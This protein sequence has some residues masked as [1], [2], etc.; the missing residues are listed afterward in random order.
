[1]EIES[2][3][4]SMKTRSETTVTLDR[5]MID[6]HESPES[7]SLQGHR[8]PTVT[9]ST[10]PLSSWLSD[11]TSPPASPIME[12]RRGGGVKYLLLLSFLAL[13]CA[14]TPPGR[15][16]SRPAYFRLSMPFTVD[17]RSFLSLDL[18]ADSDG[19]VV[20]GYVEPT[21]TRRQSV[22]VVAA[23]SAGKQ[24]WSRTH[25]V[26]RP[27]G[28]LQAIRT[29]DGGLLVWGI[30]SEHPYLLRIDRN[31]NRL[32]NRTY[33]KRSCPPEAVTQT[34]DGGFILTGTTSD[35]NGRRVYLFKTDAQGDTLWFRSFQV[36]Y[37]PGPH[38]I[39]Q[40]SDGGYILTGAAEG[41]VCIIR[42]DSDGEMLWSRSYGNPGIEFD[43]GWSVQQVRDGGFVVAGRL[44][45]PLAPDDHDMG[46]DY[47][48]YLVRMESNGD[49]LWT[50]AYGGRRYQG[51][52]WVRQTTDGGFIVVGSD[53]QSTSGMTSQ[54]DIRTYVVRTN[55]NGDTLWTRSLGGMRDW[56]RWSAFK[57]TDD[58]MVIAALDPDDPF[59]N[60]LTGPPRRVRPDRVSVRVFSVDPAG[61]VSR[62]E[63]PEEVRDFQEGLA[64][65]KID[66]KWGYVDKAAKFVIAPQ[67]DNA[68]HFSEGLAAV[69][70]GDR[71]GFISRNGAYV[72]PPQFD[73]VDEFTHGLAPVKAGG[74][75]GFVDTTG[76]LVIAPQFNRVSYFFGLGPVEIGDTW[77]FIDRAG[78]EVYRPAPEDVLPYAVAPQPARLG[79]GWGYKDSTGTFVIA[80]RFDEARSFWMGLA[81]VK[82]GG[83]WHYID[84]AGRDVWKERSGKTR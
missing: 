41:D 52:R 48:A 63:Y 7:C 8:M 14:A 30:G 13:S 50:R 38:A 22:E 62:P 82:T 47:D 24:L 71:W 26:K 34:S 36:G 70:I 11:L 84:K 65:A 56:G 54:G 3:P 69:R 67:F 28:R 73:S 83:E 2:L 72:T 74:K 40:T 16:A 44:S 4:A 6:Y 35:P 25:T 58:G 33:D 1:M 45:Q 17:P 68:Y 75:W 42:A 76:R 15:P 53:D 12:R 21:A 49:S 55:A 23:D 46:P 9:Y 27:V 5:I 79:R 18:L 32:W 10:A 51:G 29:H 31:G 43:E 64:P 39:Q 20:V 78:N 37:L 61:N 59:N 80:P 66:T 57:T 19:Y 81:L 60:P 77:I